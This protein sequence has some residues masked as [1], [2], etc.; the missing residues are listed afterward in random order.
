MACHV[1][2]KDFTPIRAGQMFCSSRCFKLAILFRKI[3]DSPKVDWT[4]RLNTVKKLNLDLLNR[5]H[6]NITI[7]DS[8]WIWRGNKTPNTYGTIKVDGKICVAHRLSLC[9][10]L[11]LD[12]EDMEWMACHIC[13]YKKCVNPTHLYQ[14]NRTTNWQD[15]YQNGTNWFFS[16]TT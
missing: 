6:K 12:Y 3:K 13:P 9:I 15:W 14:G 8:H 5:L 16:G 2:K 7:I 10:Y 4:D 11:K 1:C